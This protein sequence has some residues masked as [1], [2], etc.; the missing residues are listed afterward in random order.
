MTNQPLLIFGTGSLARMAHFYATEEMKLNVLGFVVDEERYNLTECCGLPVLRWDQEFLA[1]HEK[2]KVSIF[3]ALGYREMIQRQKLFDRIKKADFYLINIISKSAFVANSAE[4]GVNNIFMPGTVIEPGVA[5]GNNNVFWSNTTICH[6]SIIGNHNFFASNVTVGGEV[7]IGDRC[8]FGFTS[9]V[10][11]QRNVCNDV[12]LAAQS[13][14][15]NDGKS[16]GLYRGVPAR[17]AVEISNLSG[18]QVK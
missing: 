8:F 18:V 17:R 2:S 16:L 11:H 15:L 12:L 9:T 14:L 10:A 13:L 5:I 3:V 4:M 6:D 7:K 1:K